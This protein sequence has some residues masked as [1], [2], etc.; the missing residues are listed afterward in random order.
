MKT[1]LVITTDIVQTKVEASSSED[2]INKVLYYD[3][4]TVAD[5]RHE[6]TVEEV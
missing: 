2:A 3:K 6:V 1:Y 5:E 4:G